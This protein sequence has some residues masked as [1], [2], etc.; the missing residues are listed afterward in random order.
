MRLRHTL[1]AALALALA[2]P[3]G[4]QVRQPAPAQAAAP[5]PT[6]LYRMPDVSRALNLTPQQQT[7]LNA[8][9]EQT[10]ARYAN[11][12]ARLSSLRPADRV[13]ATEQLDRRFSADFLKG[14]QGVL[15]REQFG[16]YQQL[17]YQ[18]GGFST[19]ADPAVQQRLNLAPEQVTEL[20]GSLDWSARTLRAVD[21]QM[22]TDPTLGRQQYREY[23]RLYQE[24]MNRLLTPQQQQAWR[25]MTG[26]P[27]A[28]EGLPPLR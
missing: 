25:E 8:V 4:A 16:R 27:Y 20:R 23:Q 1:G 9:A 11:D 7:Q 12:Y 14:A 2:A 10:A 26:P 15:N 19:L 21:S 13:A 6:P 22:A 3:L 28:F 18:Y 24:R 17:Q 5:M